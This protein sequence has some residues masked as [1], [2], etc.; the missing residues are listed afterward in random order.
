MYLKFGSGGSDDVHVD[1]VKKMKMEY[2]FAIAL[3]S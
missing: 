3:V 1:Y 2:S